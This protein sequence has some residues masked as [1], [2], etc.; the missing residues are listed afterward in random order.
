MRLD[1]K[2]IVLIHN[3]S[4]VNSRS[5]CC[6]EIALNYDTFSS[7]V[8]PSNMESI[9]TPQICKIFDDNNW[10]YVYPRTK[11]VLDVCNFV[12]D[13]QKFK[14]TSISVGVKPEWV[15]LVKLLKEKEYSVEYFT[16]DVA[17]SYNDNV[18]PILNTIRKYYPDSYI[19][20]GNGATGEWA[21][22]VED[23]SLV[24]AIKLNIGVSSACRTKQFTGFS[25]STVSS[26][27]ECVESVRT[28]D[29]IADGGLTIVYGLEM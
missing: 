3:K 18:L 21:R 14:R 2:D 28:L 17:L 13:A 7:P 25:S 20:L 8:I 6:T 16:V 1:Y 12:S 22:W 9:M 5:E 15:E 26:L 27:I 11:G 23:L 29:V 19:I 24:N 10:L 4:I